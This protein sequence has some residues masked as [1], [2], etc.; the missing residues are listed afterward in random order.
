MHIS[1]IYIIE[2]LDADIRDRKILQ[3]RNEYNEELSH[4]KR[5]QLVIQ[6]IIEVP[7]IVKSGNG[8]SA[9]QIEQKIST[10]TR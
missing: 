10:R 1:R 2:W 6:R 8:I 3:W 9:G 4:D 5:G 7:E